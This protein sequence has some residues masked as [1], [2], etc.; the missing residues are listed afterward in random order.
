MVTRSAIT[1]PPHP[2]IQPAPPARPSIAHTLYIHIF[3]IV[4]SSRGQSL[5]LISL[6]RRH[7]IHTRLR[8]RERER[9]RER[10]LADNQEK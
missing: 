1:S 3:A 6:S 10:T 4:A 8:A 9:K 5:C 2:A 7:G